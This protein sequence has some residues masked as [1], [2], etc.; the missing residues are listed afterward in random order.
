MPTLQRTVT[1]AAALALAAGLLIGC[2]KKKEQQPV[3]AAPAPV[4][5]VDPM[6]GIDLDA[7]VQWPEKHRPNTPEQAQA[8][9]ALANAIARG[10]AEGAKGV[11][12]ESDR[13]VLA[14]LIEFGDWA[15]QTKGI[16]AVRVCVLTEGDDKKS[17][18]LGLGVQDKQAAYML[19]WKG[20]QSENGTAWSI[21]G[22]AIVPTTA[23]SVAMLDDA[24]LVAP[25]VA[26]AAVERAI[27]NDPKPGDKKS[28]A[29]P[30]T[31]N[32]PPQKRS[33]FEK[34]RDE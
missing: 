5:A 14:N 15:S 6:E 17:F 8:I 20:N 24:E 16:E 23:A 28:D 33:P 10:D 9:A 27:F 29:D 2:D 3:A 12:A 21:S 7:K 11:L 13:E 25:T 26:A 19:A 1:T 22:M 34:P 31:S 30:G 18:T 32:E 4:K